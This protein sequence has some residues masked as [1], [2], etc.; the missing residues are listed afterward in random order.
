MDSINTVK[1][2]LKITVKAKKICMFKYTHFWINKIRENAHWISQLTQDKEG[3]GI[4]KTI[5]RLFEVDG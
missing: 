1:R 2:I 3:N 4:L 5:F